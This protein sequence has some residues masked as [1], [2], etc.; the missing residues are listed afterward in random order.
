M[1][2]FSIC[3]KNPKLMTFIPNKS[4]LSFT[5]YYPETCLVIFCPPSQ[6][7]NLVRTVM[8]KIINIADNVS[9]IQTFSSYY[10]NEIQF[11][12]PLLEV[13]REVFTHHF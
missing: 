11:F 5:W 6:K 1:V 9:L 10:F 2:F 8:L 12:P 13:C 7:I 4:Y 3:I